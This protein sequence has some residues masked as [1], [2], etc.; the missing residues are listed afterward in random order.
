M[1]DTLNIAYVEGKYGANLPWNISAILAVQYADQRTVGA[2]LTN[3]GTSYQ[4]NE[5][6]SRLE[7][8]G[9]GT[10]ILTLGFSTV[11]PTFAMVNPWSSN[12]V[13][14]NSLIQS[15]Q[16]A[17]E[18]TLMAGLSYVMT[19][20]GLPGVAASVFYMQRLDDRGRRGRPAER[21]RMGLQARMATQ[22]KP[23]PGLWIRA[24]YGSSATDQNN[25]R[26]T[27]DEVRL[28]L[29]YTLNIY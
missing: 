28:V 4:T 8:G 9:L 13:Y 20:I 10:G 17:G 7:F 27:I 12:P 18:S 25:I 16:R 15:F 6:G 1:Q 14:T 26:T 11:N 24:Q 21:A 23:L 22:W 2:N 19:P 29:N 5:F 3:G